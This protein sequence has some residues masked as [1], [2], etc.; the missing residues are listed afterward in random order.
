MEPA[1]PGDG[2]D[3]A[4]SAAS[5]RKAF[6]RY[7]RGGD[8]LPWMETM[9]GQ[10]Q[11]PHSGGPLGSRFLLAR[12]A[13]RRQMLVAKTEHRDVALRHLLTT[14]PKFH[15]PEGGGLECWGLGPGPLQLITN[16]VSADSLTLETGAGLSTVCFAIQ[17]SEHICISPSPQ[18]HERIRAYCRGHGI[19][20]HRIRFVAMPSELYLPTLELG[21]RKL[22]F[23]L[24]DG[25][26][27]FPF[28]IID[29]FYV[30][31]HLR[32]GALLALDDV[33][34]PSVGVLHRYLL[35]EPAFEFVRFIGP[36]LGVYRKVGETHISGACQVF[37]KKRNYSHLPL[38][39][40]V[41]KRI[42]DV[43]ALVKSYRTLVKALGL[44][45]DET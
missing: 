13:M 30:N 14:R 32:R 39:R 19:S 36:R 38:W 40:Q 43:P 23:A 27:G 29:Y 21:G 3:L 28:A 37:N 42:E 26:H 9:S 22:D 20:T 10:I 8:R 41:R 6:V 18:E 24:I 4:V 25:A 15:S 2:C 17:G 7:L 1:N 11:E 16:T 12:E 31:R 35:T 44:Q 5:W 33:D 34:W 45:M